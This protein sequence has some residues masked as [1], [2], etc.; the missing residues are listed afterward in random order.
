MKTV[1]PRFLLSAPIR[2]PLG[3]ITAAGVLH[4]RGWSGWK[5][6]RVLGSYALVLITAGGGSY[7]DTRGCRREVK[8]GDVIW[9]FP[10]LGH[11]Y[12]PAEGGAWT[13]L[14]VVFTGPAFDLLRSTG[15]IGPER[16]VWRAAPVVQRRRELAEVV[17][18]VA[19]AG[20][21]LRRVSALQQIVVGLASLQPEVGEGVARPA[22]LSEACRRIEQAPAGAMDWPALA[23]ALDMSYESFRKKFTVK[24]GCSPGRYRQTGLLD[25]A[26]GLLLTRD[27]THKEIAEQLGFAD[28][29]HFSKAFKQRI[30]I[31]PAVF[32]AMAGSGGQK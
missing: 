12:G 4:K 6:P 32:R 24:M 19:S 30:G 5:P 7:E 14:F 25:R 1:R 31:A 20:E 16:P 21:A 13:E 2:S 3:A 17:R 18:P 15:V 23:A 8:A 26:C 9:V 28:E 10:E 22:W 27:L 11:S 29:F